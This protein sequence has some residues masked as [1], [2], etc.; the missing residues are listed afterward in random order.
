MRNARLV[1]HGGIL[2]AG[3]LICSPAAR[4]DRPDPARPVTSS[5]DGARGF[6]DTGREHLKA[7][8]FQ[9]AIDSFRAALLLS[10]GLPDAVRGL[11]EARRGLDGAKPAP[12]PTVAA[13]PT[14]KA[15]RPGAA[16]TR[17]ELV[18]R[19]ARLLQHCN[20]A[21]TALERRNFGRA[22][23][24]YEAVLAEARD[25]AGHTDVSGIQK[26][27]RE[28][29]R[30]AREGMGT[31]V[32]KGPAPAEPKDGPKAEADAPAATPRPVALEPRPAAEPIAAK[33]EEPADVTPV[34]SAFNDVFDSAIEETRRFS[35]PTTRLITRN[36]FPDLMGDVARPRKSPVAETI[37][38]EAYRDAGGE[39]RVRE[40]QAKLLQTVSVRF[41]DEPF[42][43]VLDYIAAQAD[44]NVL[45]DP[46]V[47]PL[48]RPVKKF[49]ANNMEL[50][51]VL[52]WLVKFQRLDY[53]IKDGAI[54]ISNAAGL[55][56]TETVAH[57]I[58][59]LTVQ[60]KD[61][62]HSDVEVMSTPKWQKEKWGRHLFGPDKEKETLLARTR[63]GEDWAR[64]I[65]ENVVPGTWGG[66]TAGVRQNTIAYRNGK[67][68]VTH[69][70]EVQEQI[71][72]LLSSFRKARAIQVA[73]LARFIEVN[74]DFLEDF[75]V[76]W[77]GRG[78]D[79]G[80]FD[81]DSHANSFGIVDTG[82]SAF[83]RFGLTNAHEVGFSSLGHQA[84]QGMR[85]ELGFLKTWELSAVLTAVRK[86][87]RGN[88]LT[89]PRVT[90]FNTQRAFMTVTTRRNF[91][92]SYDAD[93]NPEIGQVNDGIIFEV[94]PFVS[95][96]RR[97]IT[98]ELIP[99]VNMASEFVEFA[100]RRDID[101]DTT[102]DDDDDDTTTEAEDTIQ[103][104]EVTTRQV[105][106]TVSV[107]DGGTLMIGGLA[108]AT[109][110]EGY[111]TVPFLGDIPLLKY[112]FMSKRKVD[113]RNNLIVL[114]T[115]HIIQQEEEE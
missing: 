50:R 61:F 49:S 12:E 86:E 98:L 33:P 69:T 80:A 22:A 13:A 81:P 6:V 73:I 47:L 67:L 19:K 111:A 102:V 5:R 27:G 9:K 100:F 51:H 63:E 30:L 110:S 44:V 56:D 70:A 37:S 24:R 42:D 82:G 58:S 8:R 1:Q 46:D 40:I 23:E 76:D 92:R 84:G 64:F 88:I 41:K 91:V 25:L 107:P 68:V 103:L 95:A 89:A 54:F 93:G 39:A 106:T 90:C 77:S 108:Q 79:G 113:A 62:K 35:R 36:E 17:E 87:K 104:P 21:R 2:L 96:D 32:A 53:K 18:R 75:G 38:P 66:E 20:D 10:P 16:P 55:S 11:A 45:I 115:A 105:M 85:L 52:T 72:E 83:K 65:R 101:D 57:D 112:L 109:E 48:C 29:L 43:Q 78:P 94:Q 99:Q 97:Y 114:V 4:A 28:G 26:D 34:S 7:G 60:V 15:K 74:E 59:D 71:R 14:P 3:I 31:L